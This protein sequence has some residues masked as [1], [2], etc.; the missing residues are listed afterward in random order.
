MHESSPVAAALFF[1]PSLWPR[2]RSTRTKMRDNDDDVTKLLI[3]MENHYDVT[4]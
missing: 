2:Q 4:C 1:I 3:H